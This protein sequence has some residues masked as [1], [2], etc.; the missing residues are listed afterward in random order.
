MMN[1]LKII[2]IQIDTAVNAIRIG[3]HEAICSCEN[4]QEKEAEPTW[5]SKSIPM[6][7]I[8][9]RRWI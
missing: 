1:I 7:N 4:S 6:M 9:T 3:Y 5:E 8:W 2:P